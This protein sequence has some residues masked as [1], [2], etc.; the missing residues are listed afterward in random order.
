MATMGEHPKYVLNLPTCVGGKGVTGITGFYDNDFVNKTPDDT[1]I[2]RIHLSVDT[3]SSQMVEEMVFEFTHDIEM[4]W[5]LPG[6][7]PTGKKVSIPLV[8]SIGFS[9]CGNKVVSERI[10]WDQAGVLQQIGKLELG[11]K[12]EKL[13][14][15]GAY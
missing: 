2:T 12:V 6:V 13:P 7:A 3:K 11:K 10:Y 5:M 14:I 4:P 8:V 15:V 1:K 9:D